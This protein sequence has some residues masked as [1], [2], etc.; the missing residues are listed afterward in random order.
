[1]NSKTRQWNVR[2]TSERKERE[3]EKE[4]KKKERGERGGGREKYQ[5]LEL[6]FKATFKEGLKIKPTFFCY[7]FASNTKSAYYQY[8]LS[9]SNF[10]KIQPSFKWSNE[11]S[12]HWFFGILIPL[13]HWF[14]IWG[15]ITFPRV[16]VKYIGY[17]KTAEVFKW[18][19]SKILML[20][21]Y[22]TI[23]LWKR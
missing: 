1:M 22:A 5:N 13:E 2:Y 3:R 11:L 9:I 12:E 7:F 21:D 10:H 8:V 6:F 14:P 20:I 15:H 4:R 23:L 18:A 16:F 19:T 17:W